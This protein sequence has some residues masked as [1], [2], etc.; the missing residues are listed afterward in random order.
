DEAS[1]ELIEVDVGGSFGVRGEFYPEDLLIP[2]AAI[3]LGRPV[4]WIEDRRESF[5]ATNHSRQIECELEIAARADGT[6]LGLRGRLLA[7][8][9]AYV[10]TNGGV[11]PA[12]AAQFL[13]GPYRIPHFACEVQ[14][15]ITNKTPVGTYRG[16]GRFEANFFRERLLDLMASDL[17]LDPADVRLRNL[18]TPAELP[19]TIGTLV[20]YEASGA[21]D[22]GDYAAA[23]R[24]ALEASDYARRA[25]ANGRPVAGE[26]RRIGS[27]GRRGSAEVAARRARGEAR[28]ARRGGARMPRRRRVQARR[29]GR[30]S[31]ADPR[32]QCPGGGRRE[33]HDDGAH[34]HVRRARRP[35][36]GRSGDRGDGRA[37]PRDGRG[38]RP[39]HQPR[40]RARTGAR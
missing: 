20:P 35:R 39:R 5:L 37:A 17:G 27:G 13:P 18:I 7:D 28:R 38:R 21:Y 3:K 24:R 12:K 29:R 15:V 2:L 1:I 22:G 26:R 36:R 6:V 32:D 23:R 10:R 25:K 31:G 8:M 16:P 30:A 14:A 33:V 34:V 19:W 40:A 11:V 9:G 4:K